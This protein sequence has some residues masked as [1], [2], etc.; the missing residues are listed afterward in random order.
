MTV[1][2]SSLKNESNAHSWP[3]NVQEIDQKMLSKKRF[4]VRNTTVNNLSYNK[5]ADEIN[6]PASGL[7]ND[8]NSIGVGNNNHNFYNRYNH[9][10]YTVGA[11]ECYCISCEN[12]YKMFVGGHSSSPMADKS[13]NV[14]TKLS[15]DEIKS[16]E[17]LIS[18]IFEESDLIINM[19]N[20]LLEHAKS[21]SSK[22]NVKN[23]LPVPTFPIKVRNTNL[24]R[25]ASS[26][27]TINL[28][29]SASSLTNDESG[30]KH[31]I[32]TT[33]WS[34]YASDCNCYLCKDDNPVINDDTKI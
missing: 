34:D 11:S 4:I 22:F 32:N 26:A 33:F 15:K 19:Q 6:T 18:N 20:S 13:Q 12:F 14:P 16:A 1:N 17:P 9:K 8:I 2:I 3:K 23:K 28:Q 25:V 31:E 27:T 10:S 24:C 30:P 29:N 5:A 7:D 21:T